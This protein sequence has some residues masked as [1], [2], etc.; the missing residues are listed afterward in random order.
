MDITNYA[1]FLNEDANI[2]VLLLSEYPSRTQSINYVGSRTN[3]I[4]FE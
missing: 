2:N 4:D 1:N 3:L